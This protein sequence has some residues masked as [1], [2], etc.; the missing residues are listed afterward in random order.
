MILDA[1]FPVFA[2]IALGY[3]LR[4]R[5]LTNRNFLAVG[6]RVVYFVFF[7][8]LLP[9]VSARSWSCGCSR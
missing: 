2:L 1:V 4:R 8:A 7:P 6:D 3:A 5:G 9:P